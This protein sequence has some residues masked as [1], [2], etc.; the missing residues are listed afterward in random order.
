MLLFLV[1]TGSLVIVTRKNRELGLARNS[2]ESANAL[3]N[4]LA[5]QSRTVHWEVNAEGLY[6]YVS[7]VSY[8]VLGYRPEELVDKK[9]FYDLLNE[10][11]RDTSKT[12]AFEF[13]AQKEPLHDLENTDTDQGRTADLDINEWGSGS[14]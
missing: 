3:F 13:F 9:H 1:V 4:Q 10:D 12:V 14:G 7:P 5:E 8:A 6:T 2:A 11:E